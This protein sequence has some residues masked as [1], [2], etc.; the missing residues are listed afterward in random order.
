MSTSNEKRSRFV[1]DGSEIVVPGDP[2]YEEVSARIAREEAERK[3]IGR[4][5]LEEKAAKAAKA[6]TKK[7]G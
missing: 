2:R 6:G 5:Y 7:K 1:G 3:E 4:K